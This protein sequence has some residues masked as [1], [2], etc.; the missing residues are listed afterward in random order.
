MAK[1]IKGEHHLI[2]SVYYLC[3]HTVI[4]D[5]WLSLFKGMQFNMILFSI[6]PSNHPATSTFNPQQVSCLIGYYEG[7][8]LKVTNAPKYY[9]VMWDTNGGKKGVQHM[10]FCGFV[11]HCWHLL[12]SN[13]RDLSLF[14]FFAPLEE[15]SLGWLSKHLLRSPI[16]L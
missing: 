16:R 8:H 2:Q 11:L 1:Y 14:L 7:K 4:A 10:F 3:I 15:S 13:H 9:P 6:L 5:S 12:I